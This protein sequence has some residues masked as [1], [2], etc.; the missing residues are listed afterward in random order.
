MAAE[1][2]RGLIGPSDVQSRNGVIDILVQDE[3]AAVDTARQY[4]SYFQ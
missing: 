1:L 4:L 3:I 2:D